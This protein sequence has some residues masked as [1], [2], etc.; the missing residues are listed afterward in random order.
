M[1]FMHAKCH[2][3][4]SVFYYLQFIHFI[5]IYILFY[6]LPNETKIAKST[7]INVTTLIKLGNELS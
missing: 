5:T 6:F 3:Q 1:N 4:N 2:I 7:S